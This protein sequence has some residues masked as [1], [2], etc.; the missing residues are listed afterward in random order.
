MNGYINN[1]LF[2]VGIIGN[3]TDSYKLGLLDVL[4]NA[5]TYPFSDSI[6]T[7]LFCEELHAYINGAEDAEKAADVFMQ[8]V[9]RYL[10]EN[11][12]I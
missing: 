10:S 3:N 12:S 4:D 6:V 5:K 11:D 7:A 8:R 2:H 1:D 9:N